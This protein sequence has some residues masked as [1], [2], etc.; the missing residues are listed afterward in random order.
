MNRYGALLRRAAVVIVLVGSPF[1]VL[2]LLLPAALHEILW[3]LVRACAIAFAAYALF[4][5]ALMRR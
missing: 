1:L 2:W 4:V 5:V 3:V